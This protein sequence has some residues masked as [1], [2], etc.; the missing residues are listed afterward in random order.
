L[1]GCLFKREG[2]ALV[3]G[4]GKKVRDGEMGNFHLFP[5]SHTAQ[6]HDDFHSLS[7]S[8]FHLCLVSDDD[9]SRMMRSMAFHHKVN[10]VIRHV[11]DHEHLRQWL[12]IGTFI[13]GGI[14]L[15]RLCVYAL[16]AAFR[17]CEEEEVEEEEEELS[18]SDY[19]KAVEQV[20]NDGIEDDEEED[21]DD[22]SESST[23][24]DHEDDDDENTHKS[25]QQE[26][27][28]RAFDASRVL[29][30]ELRAVGFHK[31]TRRLH[32]PWK[33]NEPYC[34]MVRAM[35][36]VLTHGLQKA[37][38]AFCADDRMVFLLPRGIGSDDSAAALL[39]L[40]S[41]AISI[42]SNTFTTALCSTYGRALYSFDK[43][44]TTATRPSGVWFEASHTQIFTADPF[45]MITPIDV[46]RQVEEHYRN[47]LTTTPLDR[48]MHGIVGR[49][50]LQG[51]KQPERVALLA[52]LTHH[53]PE[54]LDPHLL[55]GTF[56]C[57]MLPLPKIRDCL[58]PG[59]T[60][61]KRSIVSWHPTSIN[62]TDL[63][64]NILIVMA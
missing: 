36:E 2:A 17:G 38:F 13:L 5:P 45:H 6:Q 49:G 10:E 19:D 21:D 47:I 61:T 16:S 28:S 24:D 35:N 15:A 23:S 46:V 44:T 48:F 39:R 33:R 41:R 32:K 55:V 40:E 20:I 64:T 62:H 51:M 14:L 4:G 1:D 7:I 57:P 58:V 3:E 11:L 52:S 63:D 9:Q 59:R 42:A 29:L 26:S 25:E 60:S 8:L 22:E 56:A 12:T 34:A 27:G 54:S 43:R 50:V 18:E 37:T 31:F 30:I 53:T